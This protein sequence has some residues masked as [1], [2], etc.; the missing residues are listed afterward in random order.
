MFNIV[1]GSRRA[2]SWGKMLLE[3]PHGGQWDRGYTKLAPQGPE[4][5]AE[6][7]MPMQKDGG[8]GTKILKSGTGAC[9]ADPFYRLEQGKIGLCQQLGR[10]VVRVPG[11]SIK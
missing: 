5:A 8:T 1:S 3:L 10:K 2:H 11:T 9:S 4:D 6:E 7:G